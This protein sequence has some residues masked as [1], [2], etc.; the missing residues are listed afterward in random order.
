M[1]KRIQWIDVLKFI[2]I[3]LVIVIHWEGCPES[4]SSFFNTFFLACFYFASGYCYKPSKDFKS[5][6]YKKFR[7]L[8]IPWLFFSNLNII[9]SSIMSFQEHNTL[10]NEIIMNLVQIRSLGD[11]QWFLASLFIS[12]VPFYF[13]V[14]TYENKKRNNIIFIYTLMF[15]ILCSFIKQL[16]RNY[17]FEYFWG[18]TNLP[19]HLEA[20]GESLSLMMFGYIFKESIE[21]D[22]DKYV[23][24]RLLIPIIF[25]YLLISYFVPTLYDSVPTIIKTILSY[26]VEYAGVI[27]IIFV[28]KTIKPNKFVLF[29]GQH[30]LSIFCIQRKFETILQELLSRLI[31]V[32][33][34]FVSNNVFV[35]S[36]FSIVFA[37]LNLIVL[38]IPIIIVEKI[39]PFIFG[40]K[41]NVSL[42]DL[43]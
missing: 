10:K 20:V 26:F 7:T 18:N 40:S 43:V 31:P 34:E 36:M 8:F 32:F 27:M 14:K 37:L 21:K 30:T 42:K 17:G 13:V 16:M 11:Q 2:C 41:S 39:L 19:W 6:L 1:N 35:G 15:G 28:S 22:F 5:L 12:F 25:L 4:F 3:T 23:S 38:I 33:Y 29:F 24:I 9:L